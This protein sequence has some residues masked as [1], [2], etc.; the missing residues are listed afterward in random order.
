[1]EVLSVFSTCLLKG[2]Q[3]SETSDAIPYSCGRELRVMVAPFDLLSRLRTEILGGSAL[4]T[5][6]LTCIEE[7]L[8][9]AGRRILPAL[10]IRESSHSETKKCGTIEPCLAFLFRTLTE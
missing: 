1:M 3:L 6:M 7:V 5:I 8:E 9:A 4:L 2:K 10:E